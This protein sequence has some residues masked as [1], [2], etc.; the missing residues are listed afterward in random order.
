MVISADWRKWVTYTMAV[1]SVVTLH[2][3]IS[4]VVTVGDAVLQVAQWQ[5]LCGYGALSIFLLMTS[6]FFK[7]EVI[8]EA[9]SWG[10]LSVVTIEAVYGMLQLYGNMSSGHM[11]FGLTGS[12]Y[13]PGP[14]GGFL[15]LGVPLAIDRYYAERNVVGRYIAIGCGLLVVSMLPATMSR[16]AW[17][18]SLIA[19]V[20]MLF[21]HG[22]LRLRG[23]WLMVA[24]VMLV[25]GI[26]F[27]VMVTCFKADS[28]QGRLHLWHMSLLALLESP[29]TGS[30]SF[31]VS[32]AEA[33]ER[34]FSTFDVTTLTQHGATCP[35]YAFN[36]YLHYAVEYGV[37]SVVV[38]LMIVLLLSAVGYKNRDYGLLGVMLCI[39]I[40]AFASY[41]LHLPMFVAVVLLVSLAFVIRTKIRTAYVALS[42]VA[43]SVGGV[44]ASVQKSDEVY[45]NRRWSSMQYLYANKRY[46][47]AREQY[48]KI[49]PQMKNNGYFLFEYGHILHNLAL[50]KQSNDILMVCAKRVGDPMVLN[51]IGKNYKL[52]GDTDSAEHYFRKSIDRL[53]SRMYP[54]NLLFD[55]QM[56]EGDTSGMIKTAEVINKTFK[57]ESSATR[58]MRD[59]VNKKIKTLN[60]K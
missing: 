32:Y 51:I 34:Y 52:S 57:V 2:Y 53:P 45:A 21:M 14:Y 39:G 50:P 24:T 48:D 36:E 1:V 60:N 26:A 29:W 11:L 33:Q 15:A 49:L 59:D 6:M 27:V 9:L 37:P 19:G 30:D 47:M 42:M 10:V 13:N 58:E 28:A 31:A 23:R 18:A 55:L 56:A 17:V 43:L 7:R 5:A 35:H 4:N 54:Y 16:T 38:V 40:F 46:E 3:G 12:F 44:I 22:K 20:A 25:L 41:P 8:A